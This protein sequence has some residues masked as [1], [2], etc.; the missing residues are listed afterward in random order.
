MRFFVH[1]GLPFKTEVPLGRYYLKYATG[2]EWYGEQ[3]H[4][5]PKTIY[6]KAGT[7]L[8]FSLEDGMITELELTLYRVRNGNLKTE[9]ISRENF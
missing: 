2:D 6:A 1:G 7:V 4:F 9:S 5:G 8:K 3:A